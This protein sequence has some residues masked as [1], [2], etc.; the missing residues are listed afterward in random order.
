[1]AGG[2]PTVL[3]SLMSG[4]AGR[5][6]RRRFLAGVPVAAAA[7][8]ACSRDES[9]K[10]KET[11]VDTQSVPQG[12]MNSNSRLDTALVRGPVDPQSITAAVRA[13]A[14]IPLRRYD[15][16][17]PPLSEATTH[18][19]H[20]RAQELPIRISPSVVVAGWTFEGDIPG[21]ILHVREGDTV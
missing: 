21:P 9:A 8:A 16:A 11:A 13:A 15:P 1:M 20:W 14:E 17:L 5:V 10:S 7:V 18:Q 12:A 6:S 2:T 3:A 19:V 4:I